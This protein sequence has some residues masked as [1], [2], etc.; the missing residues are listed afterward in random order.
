M[1]FGSLWN[2][3][4]KKT[5]EENLKEENLFCKYRLIKENSAKMMKH[6]KF[7]KSFIHFLDS[8]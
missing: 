3:M 2:F 8:P 1:F 5:Q 4:Y 7:S 6:R